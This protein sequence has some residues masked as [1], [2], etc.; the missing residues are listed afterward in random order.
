MPV[1]DDGIGVVLNGHAVTD[2]RRYDVC[3]SFTSVRPVVL[4]AQPEI[5]DQV[6]PWFVSSVLD[7]PFQRVVQVN[8]TCCLKNVGRPL[9]IDFRLLKCVSESLRQ[10]SA[11]TSATRHFSHSPLL[12]HVLRRLEF[13]AKKSAHD[14]ERANGQPTITVHKSAQLWLTDTCFPCDGIQ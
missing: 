6:R 13:Q 7:D 4:T 11:A 9:A 2:P 5:L 12:V 10:N 8:Q 1:A 14:I 3:R